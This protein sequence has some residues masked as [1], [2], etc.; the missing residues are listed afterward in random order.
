MLSALAPFGADG[1]VR[2][3]V[4][5]PR[6]ST[7]KYEYDP[8]LDAIRVSRQLALGLAYPYDWGFVPGT[9]AQDGDP[10]D[11]LV[12]HEAATFPGVVLD[13]AP[14]GLVAV[15]EKRKRRWISNHRLVLRPAWQGATAGMDRIGA[16]P[17]D[18]VRELEQ[19]FV[20]AVFFTGKQMSVT[21]WRGPREAIEF[22][23]RA[24]GGA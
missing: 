21:G 24:A 9:R 15:R 11:A 5:S 17:K 10:A 7:L 14:L 13:C 12:M 3:V 1:A 16:L 8:E 2:V 20:N 19:F 18:T 4:E 22:V 23:R 6:H